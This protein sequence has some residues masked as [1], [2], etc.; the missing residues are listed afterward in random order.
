MIYIKTILKNSNQ[1]ALLHNR[2][3]LEKLDSVSYWRVFT[4]SLQQKTWYKN[5]QFNSLDAYFPCTHSGRRYKQELTQIKHYFE[6]LAKPLPS[7]VRFFN[8]IVEHAHR[9]ARKLDTSAKRKTWLDS[10]WGPKFI[11]SLAK[12][13]P[14]PAFFALALLVF[15]F[16]FENRKAVSSLSYAHSLPPRHAILRSTLR[17]EPKKASASETST[18]QWSF[19]WNT[20]IRQVK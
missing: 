8:S 19:S 6:N 11:A 12:P 13:N 3:L 17:D 18:K 20:A 7:M 15:S 10:G 14:T 4:H 5:S 1:E 9:I 2:R 16:A